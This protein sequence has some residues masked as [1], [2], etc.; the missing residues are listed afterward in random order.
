MGQE[1]VELGQA[2]R[3]EGLPGLAGGGLEFGV[4]GLELLDALDMGRE[5]VGGLDDIVADRVVL[6][7]IRRHRGAQLGGEHGQQLFPADALDLLVGV[8]DGGVVVFDRRRQV[9]GQDLRGV[10]VEGGGGAALGIGVQTEDIPADQGEAVGQDGDH[11]TVL[12]HVFGK[13]VAHQAPAGDIAHP[14]D[15][16]VEAE[17]HGGLSFL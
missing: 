12:G 17:L 7:Q 6:E 5:L 8:L 15:Q 2:H 3:L 14:G 9:A 4:S 16:S 1:P 11:V 13:G 10:V